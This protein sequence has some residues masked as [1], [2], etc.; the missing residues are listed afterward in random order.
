MQSSKNH[1]LKDGEEEE[2]ELEKEERHQIGHVMMI[3]WHENLTKI[4]F[5]NI[6]SD[7]SD[8]FFI[9][10]NFC[11]LFFSCFF[12]LFLVIIVFF[13]YP[14][15][16]CVQEYEKKGFAL[17]FKGVCL[18]SGIIIVIWMSK[19]LNISSIFIPCETIP[20][21]KNNPIFFIRLDIH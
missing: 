15:D 9:P 21:K 7:K 8:P 13:C 10:Q 14:L 2:D 11:N 6:F 3:K 18:S 16:L 5:L 19:K 12:I 20:D 4:I 1:K 17:V